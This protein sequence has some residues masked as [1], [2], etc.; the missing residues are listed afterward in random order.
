MKAL[1]GG[2]VYVDPHADPIRD[3]VVLIDGGRIAEVG[4]AAPPAEATIID[5]SGLTVTAGFWN[6]HVHFF[7]RK[8]ADAANIPAPELARQLHDTYPR[9][10]FTSVF[11]L[12]SSFDNTRRL[13]ER[14]ESGEIAGPRIRTTGE[15]LVPPGALPPERVMQVMG[16]VNT[17]LPEIGDAASAAAHARRLLDAGTD[18]VKLF[19]AMPP[20]AIEAAVAEAH[21]DGKPVFMHPNTIDDAHAAL[22]AG[23]DV[24]AHTTP[25][26]GA[27]TDLV[28]GG[29]ALTPTL[30]LWK[31]FL[32]H[33]RL[34]VQEQ[35]VETAVGQLRSWIAAGGEV[36]FGTDLGAVDPDPSEEYALMRAAGMSFRQILASLT[37]SPAARFGGSGR[38]AAGA[39]ANLVAFEGDFADVRVTVTG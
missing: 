10:G 31:F 16:V 19:A 26:S 30:T 37:T 13:R 3:G 14:I 39:P 1:V 8:W 29:A 12:S 11:D 22:R 27:W 32:R 38:I 15:G 28:P 36:L 24:I 34:S 6:S 4:T 35:M 33:D 7:E 9:Y 23:V 25:R 5:C 2:T 20:G 18:G 21:R 17:P